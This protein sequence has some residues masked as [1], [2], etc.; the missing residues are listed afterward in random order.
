MTMASH[1]RVGAAF[2]LL[3]MPAVPLHAHAQCECYCVDGKMQSICRSAT[4]I[5]QTCIPTSC[6]GAS[7]LE[8]KRNK[9]AP[10]SELSAATQNAAYCLGVLTVVAP[11][12][13]V[14][15]GPDGR[16]FHF[17]NGTTTADVNSQMSAI[18]RGDGRETTG[19]PPRQLNVSERN[20]RQRFDR[21][22]R[23]IKGELLRL[24]MSS[25]DDKWAAVGQIRRI[26][27]YGKEDAE[28]SRASASPEYAKCEARC[29]AATPQ[30]LVDCVEVYDVTGAKV[31][32]C[33]ILPDRLP[34]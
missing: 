7:T 28:R 32:A 21:H 4:D 3:A 9:A 14:V 11:S 17:P 33:H 31:L 26:E 15:S 18:Y 27:K 8:P 20:L 19:S 24:T 10:T 2:F 5:P 25:A 1:L 12:G 34:Y 30:C 23:Y 29:G 6:A 16:E 22:N 13:I